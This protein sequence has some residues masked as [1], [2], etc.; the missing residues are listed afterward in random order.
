MDRDLLERLHG[1]FSKIETPTEEEKSILNQLTGELPNFQVSSVCRDDL[2]SEGFDVT[3]VTDADMKSLAKKMSNDYCDQLYWDSMRVIAYEY[4]EIPMMRYCP[5]CR[6]C[7]VT[8][9]G[10]PGR[11]ICSSC[12]KQWSDYVLVQFPEDATYFENE[13]IG[14]PCY[15]SEDNGACYV[16]EHEY[17]LYFKKDPAPESMFRPVMW[18]DSQDYLEHTDK[19]CEVI[20]ADEKALESFGSSAV[21]VP[22]CLLTKNRE[23][24]KC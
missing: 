9:D 8:I 24:T 7:S 19:R 15:N 10:W 12:G 23:D 3:R 1:Y 11:H 21:W 14:Y 6:S 13:E 5:V 22:V 17:L 2:R 16:P 18:P 4:F 20:T